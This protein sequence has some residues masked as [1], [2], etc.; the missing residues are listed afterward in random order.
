MRLASYNMLAVA[1]CDQSGRLLGAV[2]VDDVLDRVLGSG[3][4]RIAARSPSQVPT[5]R[6]RPM[7]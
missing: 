5:A 6:R 1:V 7:W 2:T 4:P 3:L